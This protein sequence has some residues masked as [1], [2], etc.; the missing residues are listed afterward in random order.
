MQGV[1]AHI[2]QLK[3]KG[4]NKRLECRLS[5]SNI[6]QYNKSEHY[7][8]KCVGK[9]CKYYSITSRNKDNKNQTGSYIDKSIHPYLNKTITLVSLKTKKEVKIKIV[10]DSEEIPFE[11]LYSQSSKLGKALINKIIGD[12]IIVEYKNDKFIYKIKAIG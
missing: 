6:C 12:I 10:K 11:G 2:V 7:L 9:R 4:K 5:Y 3:P 8:T 1:S